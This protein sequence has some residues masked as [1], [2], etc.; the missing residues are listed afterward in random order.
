LWEACRPVER[1]RRVERVT[2]YRVSYRFG[3]HT[4][5]RWM[6]Y[7]PGKRLPIEV[8]VTTSDR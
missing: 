2:G 1:Q 3:G 7:D 4:A 6:T 8:R 5:S